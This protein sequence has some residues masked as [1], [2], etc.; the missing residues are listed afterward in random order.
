M[1]PTESIYMVVINGNLSFPLEGFAF[2]F[3]EICNELN[4]IEECVI[5]SIVDLFF[6][7]AKYF[8]YNVVNYLY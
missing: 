8:S 5:F 2:F 6:L 7:T 1:N 3:L 4:A